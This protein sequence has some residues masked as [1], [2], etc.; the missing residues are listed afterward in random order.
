MNVKIKLGGALVKYAPPDFSGVSDTVTL[1]DNSSV[2]GALDHFSIP[3]E[4]PLMVIL[5]DSMVAR[6]DYA[7]TVLANGD[8]LSLMP[9]I[10]A[11]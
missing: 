7:A 9:P 2:Q 3:S 8:T 10:T 4:Q 1:N 5:N 6:P 11:G